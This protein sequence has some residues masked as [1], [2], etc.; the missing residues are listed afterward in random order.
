MDADLLPCPFCGND[1]P[2]HCYDGALSWVS[3][4]KCGTEGPIAEGPAQQA[5]AESADAWNRAPRSKE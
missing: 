3:C 2:S 5:Y 4:G 1:D